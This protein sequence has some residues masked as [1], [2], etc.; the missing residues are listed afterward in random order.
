MRLWRSKM[1]HEGEFSNSPLLVY[2]TFG[3]CVTDELPTEYDTVIAGL[4]WGS[5]NATAFYRVGLRGDTAHVSGEIYESG[6]SSAEKYSAIAADCRAHKVNSLYIDPS[7]A[8][9]IIDLQAR[10]STRLNS[11]HGYISYAV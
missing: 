2:P 4:D 9:V 10:K 8:Q 1:I 6:K 3:D 5:T 7:A 11:S